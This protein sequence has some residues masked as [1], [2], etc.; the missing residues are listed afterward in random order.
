MNRIEVDEHMM[1][2]AVRYSLGRSTYINQDTADELRC[3]WADLTAGTRAG[4]R[5]DITDWLNKATP[6]PFGL[7]RG[8]KTSA[9]KQ[10]NEKINTVLWQV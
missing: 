10:T 7:C 3:V 1:W 8:E 9:G 2:S 6:H 4:I 5:S